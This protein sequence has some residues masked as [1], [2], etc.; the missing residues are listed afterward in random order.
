MSMTIA[1]VLTRRTRVALTERDRGLSR[2]PSIAD[3]LAAR[4]GWNTAQRAAA[5]DAY[6][7]EV[8]QYSVR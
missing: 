6:E 1:D 3:R 4:L 2:A 7:R 8:A 5:L